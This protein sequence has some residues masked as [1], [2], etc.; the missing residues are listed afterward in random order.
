M[1]ERLKNYD[2]ATDYMLKPCQSMENYLNFKCL[3]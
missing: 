1:E 3:V 2:K